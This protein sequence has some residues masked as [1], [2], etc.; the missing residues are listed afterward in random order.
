[1]YA[2]YVLTI[3]SSSVNKHATSKKYRAS[4][5]ARRERDIDPI[6]LCCRSHSSLVV[7][8]SDIP[9]VGV[10][11][12]SREQVPADAMGARAGAEPGNHSNIDW[13]M[14]T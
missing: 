13:L 2:L 3:I 8:L 7:L 14:H 10:G 11:G 12:A 1:M 9:S 5:I 6:A 4:C